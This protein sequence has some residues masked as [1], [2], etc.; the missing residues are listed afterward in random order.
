MPRCHK[1][2]LGPKKF[3]RVHSECYYYT[4]LKQQQKIFS[5]ASTH[6]SRK[7]ES[8][9]FIWIKISQRLSILA[10][11]IFCLREIISTTFTKK[12]QRRQQFLCHFSSLRFSICKNTLECLPRQMAGWL[13]DCLFCWLNALRLSKCKQQERR[14][15]QLSHPVASQ[16]ASHQEPSMQNVGTRMLA[17]N[18]EQCGKVCHYQGGE[19]CFTCL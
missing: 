7:K 8:T 10:F 19:K 18:T 15:R 3:I 14:K 13:N 6:V 11:L 2:L 4:S 12:H 17:S 16:P 1:L 9:T 5:T